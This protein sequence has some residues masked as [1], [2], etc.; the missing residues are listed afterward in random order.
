MKYFIYDLYCAQNMDNISEEQFNLI[1]EQLQQNLKE[2]QEIYK[3]LS[4]K[5][6][7]HVFNHFKSWGFHDYRLIKLELEH[8]SLLELNVIFTISNNEQEERMWLLRFERVSYFNF[9]HHNYKNEKSIFHKEIDDWLFQEI[10]PINETT[11]S[12]EVLLSSGGNVL[13]H[14]PKDLVYLERIK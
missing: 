13:L 11:F 4:D 14:F 2:Y 3:N 10:L 5:L 7:L 8:K 9:M 6:P 12:F 1:D